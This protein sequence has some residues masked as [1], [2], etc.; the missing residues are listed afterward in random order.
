MKFG[1]GL[2]TTTGELGVCLNNFQGEKK[3][4]SWYLGRKLANNLHE[5][6][7]DFIKPW[8]WQDLEF[9]AVAKGPG[10]YTSTRI[11]IVTA[12]TLAQ[13]LNIPV[14]GISTLASLAWFNCK[15][16]PNNQIIVGEMK[17]NNEEV[18]VGIYQGKVNNKIL[19]IILPDQLINLLQW[20]EKFKEYQE[21]LLDKYLYIKA[22]EQLAFTTPSLLELAYWE[23]QKNQV[24]QQFAT[25]EQL[26]PFY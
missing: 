26:T 14:Y 1:L 23:Y 20:Q 17:A 4:N 19:E 21:K 16:N 11:G 25:W 8:T 3:F 22:P 12:K 2:H 5:Y 7:A 10:S 24:I 6:L 13:Q 15:N 9:I 18:F